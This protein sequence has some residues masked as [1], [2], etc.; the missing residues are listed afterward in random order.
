M[1]DMAKQ[2]IVAEILRVQQSECI[3]SQFCQFCDVDDK[4][5]KNEE[6]RKEDQ[7]KFSTERRLPP[8]KET[9]R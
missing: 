1:V 6:K 7:D 4:E 9:C 2:I 8:Q 5:R 3:S